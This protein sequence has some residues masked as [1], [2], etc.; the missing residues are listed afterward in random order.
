MEDDG[1]NRGSQ[2]RERTRMNLVGERW[3]EGKPC[4]EGE[5]TG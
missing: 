5:S 3:S 1:V 2:G 4:N